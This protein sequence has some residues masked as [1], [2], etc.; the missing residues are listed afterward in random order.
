MIVSKRPE[1]KKLK[2]VK[3]EIVRDELGVFKDFVDVLENKVNLD[4]F[5]YKHKD[6]EFVKGIDE[7]RKGMCLA[8]YQPTKRK[9]FFTD[10][11]FSESIMHELLHVA[12]TLVGKDKIY[13]GLCQIDRN[14]GVSFGIGLTEG[15]TCLL[16]EKYFGEYTS[17]KGDVLRNSYKLLKRLCE[18]LMIIYTDD[19]IEQYYFDAD[20]Q[21]FINILANDI[22]LEEI[23]ILLCALDNM[24][25]LSLTYFNSK[26]KIYMVTKAIFKNYICAL[27]II[28]KIFYKRMFENYY[29]GEIDNEEFNRALFY[30]KEL[31][32]QEL[33]SEVFK[34]KPVK[35]GSDKFNNI[36]DNARSEILLKKKTKE[37]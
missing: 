26:I 4:I 34:M 24:H 20:L 12:S 13:L 18:Y 31:M 14:M 23:K 11:Y 19:V 21:G 33:K 22:S 6:I 29:D 16:D 3:H 8:E 1:L 5:Y 35:V 10:D 28:G 15:I 37:M 17:K 30:L 25:A 7:S 9:I 36:I 27:K 32:G 2:Y